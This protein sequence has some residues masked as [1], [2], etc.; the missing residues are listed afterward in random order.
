[1]L[2]C[3]QTL[4]PVVPGN[5]YGI[6]ANIGNAQLL[7]QARWVL[8]TLPHSVTE[9]FCSAAAF[10]DTSLTLPKLSCVVDVCVVV[11]VVMAVDACVFLL[12]CSDGRPA[13][14]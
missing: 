11:Q 6:V 14:P 7:C 4:K 10:K 12:H 13:R 3:W 1:M 2:V 5:L 8:A 9:E